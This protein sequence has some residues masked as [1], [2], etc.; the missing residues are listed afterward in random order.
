M[1]EKKFVKKDLT[2]QDVRWSRVPIIKG[3]RCWYVIHTDFGG[4]TEDE[5]EFLLF[6]DGTI[7]IGAD[8][9]LH[10]EQIDALRDFLTGN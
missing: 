4:H 3:V 6:D 1:D 9:H 2:A 5:V 7:A 8:G 10:D